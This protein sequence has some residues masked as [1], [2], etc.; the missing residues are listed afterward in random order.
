MNENE[1]ENKV[2]ERNVQAEHSNASANNA[3]VDDLNSAAAA[4]SN[5]LDALRAAL[6]R[7]QQALARAEHEVEQ[8]RTQAADIDI[9]IHAETATATAIVTTTDSHKDADTKSISNTNTNGLDSHV[10]IINGYENIS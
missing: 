4:A 3:M 7:T 1:N 6:Q 10:S 8:L 2:T 5:E 9:D